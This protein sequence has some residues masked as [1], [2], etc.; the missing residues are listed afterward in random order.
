MAAVKTLKA[1]CPLKLGLDIILVSDCHFKNCFEESVAIMLLCY[2][3]HTMELTN[4]NWFTAVLWSG[5]PQ[6]LPNV[7]R[8]ALEKK[9]TNQD[10]T[11]MSQENISHMLMIR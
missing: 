8:S 1:A 9:I 5:L 2:Y 11:V 3:L 4:G 10:S 7:P 6:A